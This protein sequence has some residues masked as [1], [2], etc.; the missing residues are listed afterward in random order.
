MAHA[1]KEDDKNSLDPGGPQGVAGQTT[2][3]PPAASKP[4]E[5]D[6]ALNNPDSTPGTGMLPD[7]GDEEP[8][9]QPSG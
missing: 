8:N 2:A 5:L 6:P 7:L 9:M 4:P 1:R 3:R